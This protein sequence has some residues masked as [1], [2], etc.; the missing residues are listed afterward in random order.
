M[1]AIGQVVV[2]GL[3]NGG[4]YGLFALGIVLV[5]RGTGALNFAQGEIGT[6]AL[7]AAWFV[8]TKLGLPWV[9]GAV[10]AIA[11]A[12]LVGVAFEA[13]VVRSMVEASRVTVAVATVGLL[14]FLLAVETRFLGGASPRPIEAPIHAEGVKLFGVIVSPTQAIALVLAIAVGLAFTVLLRRTDFGLGVLA[15]AQDPVAVRLV[16]IPLRRVSAFVWGAGAAVSALGALFIAPTVGF[17]TPGYATVLFLSGLAAAVVGGL[18]SLPGAFAGGLVVGLVEATAGRVF[19]GSSL[20]DV[21]FLAVF[22]VI[23]AVLLVR[24]E[25]LL[26]AVGAGARS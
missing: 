26:R 16:G 6:F 4:I 19:T 21:R 17:V 10:A 8:D 5:Y 15:A 14:L 9:A 1:N 22:V 24:P 7:Y 18:S 13:G 12:T 11:V 20:P 3:V 25:G 2:I 23:L